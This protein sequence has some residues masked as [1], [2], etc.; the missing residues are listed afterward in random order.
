MKRE[1]QIKTSMLNTK[2]V[3]GVSSM[4]RYGVKIKVAFHCTDLAFSYCAAN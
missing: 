2:V 1:V 4:E 3:P